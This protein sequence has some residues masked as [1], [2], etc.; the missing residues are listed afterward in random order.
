MYL[1]TCKNGSF[2][3]AIGTS[4]IDANSPVS[5]CA[6][7]LGDFLAVPIESLV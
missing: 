5:I 3:A 4:E 2:V 6:G 7:A 1:S